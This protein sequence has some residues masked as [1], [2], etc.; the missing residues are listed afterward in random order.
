MLKPG[1][2]FRRS[3]IISKSLCQMLVTGIMT[4]GWQKRAHNLHFMLLGLIYFVWHIHTSAFSGEWCRG[5]LLQ[6]FCCCGYVYP[7]Q[8]Y[9]PLSLL[10][11]REKA[12]SSTCCVVLCCVDMACSFSRPSLG[13][14]VLPRLLRLLPCAPV[15]TVGQQSSPLCVARKCCSSSL[16]RA[17]GPPTAGDS[18]WAATPGCTHLTRFT[19]LP[20]TGPTEGTRA[21]RAQRTDTKPAEILATYCSK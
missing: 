17:T 15:S 6:L 3:L 10:P 18:A 20:S 4:V 1:G 21:S 13:D 7:Q 19:R 9:T 5:L 14:P 2:H 16:W 12:S 8:Y 11:R